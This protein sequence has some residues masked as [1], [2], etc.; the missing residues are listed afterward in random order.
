MT[1][2]RSPLPGVFYAK[3]GPDKPP[4]AAPGDR[5]HVGDA[6]GIIEVMKQ[7]TEIR[8]DVE[9]VVTS[10]PVADGA[11]VMPGDVLVTIEES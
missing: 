11:S 7:F 10:V 9:G 2:I 1:E 8:S 4:F 3:P 5:I 6:V